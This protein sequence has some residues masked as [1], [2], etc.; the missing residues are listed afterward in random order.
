MGSG[1][2][3]FGGGQVQGISFPSRSMSLQIVYPTKHTSLFTE[4]KI[5]YIYIKIGA[6]TQEKHLKLSL[7][8]PHR[9]DSGPLKLKGLGL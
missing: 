2:F 7:V 4:V 3:F 8:A 5:G 6:W 1:Y 9:L